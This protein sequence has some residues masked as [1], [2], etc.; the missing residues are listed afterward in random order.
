MTARRYVNIAT[1]GIITVI[2]VAAVIFVPFEFLEY[3][4]GNQVSTSPPPPPS[5][6][7][8]GM[9]SSSQVNNSTG[10]RMNE[11]SGNSSSFFLQTSQK[12]E[13][14]LVVYF[15]ST[16]SYN[17]QVLIGSFEFPSN[18]SASSFV[19]QMYHI[20]MVQ[21]QGYNGFGLNVTNG[22]YDNFHYTSFYLNF[23]ILSLDVLIVIGSSGP[24][25]FGIYAIRC[26]IP[27][28]T[29]LIQAEIAAMTD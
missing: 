19:S 12:P 15:N 9:V 1:T 24:F 28:P 13:D 21:L 5:S 14:R 27:N 25:A 10:Q 16:E 11:S 18:S 7:H 20:E 2:V 8:I 17:G 26:I 6:I 3:H 22:S 29:T 23:N 4:H